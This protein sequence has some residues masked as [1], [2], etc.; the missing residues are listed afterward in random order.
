VSIERE[1]FMALNTIPR[2]KEIIT[3][4]QDLFLSLFTVD[5]CIVARA[6]APGHP[7]QPIYYDPDKHIAI[8]TLVPWDRITQWLPKPDYNWE[9]KYDEQDWY[10]SDGCRRVSAR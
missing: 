10:G 4:H 7:Y 5:E 6:E 3:I 1:V 9:H 2:P 8:T